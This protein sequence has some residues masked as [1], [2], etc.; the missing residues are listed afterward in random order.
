[1]ILLNRYFR[2]RIIAA[3]PEN[4]LT[5]LVEADIEI[6]NLEWLDD[7]TVEIDVRHSDFSYAKG[8]LQEKGFDI[9][10]IRRK[11]LLWQIFALWKRPVLVTGAVLFIAL[12]LVLPGR[13][14]FVEV[15]GNESLSDK[16][17]I[18]YAENCG[19]GFAAKSTDVRSENVKNRLLADLPEL[20]WLGV[21]TKG[22]VAT[23]HVKERSTQD[24]SPDGD[25]RISNIVAV[26]DGIITKMLVYSGNPLFQVGQ[27]VKNGDILISGYTDCG[28]KTTAQQ[29]EGEVYAHTLRSICAILPDSHQSRGQ[30]LRKHTC[31]RLRIGKKV[32]NLCNHSGI[33][34]AT[35]VKMYSEYYWT[36]PGG[37]QLPVSVIKVECSFHEAIAQ[38]QD[39]ENREWLLQYA[40]N[41]LQ[42]QMIAGEVL[43]ESLIWNRFDDYCVLNGSYACH[44]MIGQV[45][46]EE[47]LEQYAEDN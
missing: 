39:H 24:I 33:M 5:K 10:I 18:Q 16:L 25:D 8:I 40:R 13:I 26:Q 35:C 22:C 29:S 17:I 30:V 2:V 43:D 12:A 47:I 28:L 19:I 37:F 9:R 4:V 21:T 45:K 38:A 15:E 32:I 20:Q 11:G 1:M 41:Y 44:E 6:E 46:Y 23:I 36:L 27:T 3:D 14:F 42:S 7:L 34:D 31:Y